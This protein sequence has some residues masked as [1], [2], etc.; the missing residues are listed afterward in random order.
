M[1]YNKAINHNNNDIHSLTNRGYLY[2]RLKQYKRASDDFNQL[3]LLQPK[4]AFVLLY[5]G[6]YF[7]FL[8]T[9]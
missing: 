6:D 4:D 8:V 5:N 7:R 1:N 2:F 3:M 9:V